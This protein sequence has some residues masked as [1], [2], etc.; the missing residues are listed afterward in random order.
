MA[1]I[2]K[3]SK[4]KRDKIQGEI[5]PQRDHE[6]HVPPES[7]SGNTSGLS[8]FVESEGQNKPTKNKENVYPEETQVQYCDRSGSHERWQ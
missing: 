4:F 5:N 3:Q 2:P 1:I 8:C 7:A 6:S